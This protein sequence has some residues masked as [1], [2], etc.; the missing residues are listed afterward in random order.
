MSKPT[1]RDFLG[2]T[3]RAGAGLVILANAR[4]AHTFAANERLRTAH[5]GVGGRGGAF[6]GP[7]T[8][9][10]CDVNEQRAAA[11][12]KRFPDL[13]RYTDF[14][15]ML[16]ERAGE[17]DAVFVATPDHTHAVA[18]AA[19]IRAGKPVYCEKG[20]TRTIHE[21]RALAELTL[22][23]KVITQMGNQGGY[24]T[25]S[26][27]HLWG[28]AIGEVRQTF[29]WNDQG[30]PG[31]RPIPTD[32]PAVPAGLEWDLWLGPSPQRPYHPDWM[33]GWSGWR[34][35]GSGLLGMWG[36]HTLATT[37][38]AMKLDTLWQI[39]KPAPAGP[40]PLIRVT[41]DVPH[42]SK[43]S[44]PLWEMVRWEVPARGDMPPVTMTWLNGSKAPHEGRRAM[45][46]QH[47][48]RRI[49]WGD[50]PPDNSWDDWNGNLWI[51]SRGK[52]ESSGHGD[53]RAQFFLENKP[54]QL[55]DPPQLLPRSLGRGGEGGFFDAIRGGPAPMCNFVEFG[56][57]FA[58]WYL[59]GNLATLFPGE[60]LEYD[61]IA[62]RIVNNPQADAAARP[63]Y[64]KGWAL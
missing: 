23:Y 4:S 43:D 49:R 20:L 38:K 27:Q 60:T 42:L 44:Y 37:F 41:A 14:R 33:R 52:Y 32:T 8:A 63:E 64:R 11:A 40:R 2:N 15:K 7:T 46:E 17:I 19:A 13:P 35:F 59:L 26:V 29:S 47:L 58:E 22:Q 45:I 55:G 53:G 34:D 48:G 18:S 6:L 31:P 36:S 12:Y 10:L 51:G 5:I 61:P 1:R 24:N 16:D 21:A 54:A 62:G 28:G 57:P 50:V 3:I 30:G 56:V 25:R 39:G 9:F